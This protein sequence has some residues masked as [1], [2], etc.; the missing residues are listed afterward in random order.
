M[1]AAIAVAGATGQVDQG[2]LVLTAAF[3]IGTAIP[4]LLF[5]YAGQ[6]VGTRAARVRAGSRRF[7]VTGGVV[8]IVLAAAL[9]FNLTGDLPVSS[10][11]AGQL[12]AS[13]GPDRH[14]HLD[15]HQ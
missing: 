1:I 15:Q 6:Q 2:V 11:G 14:R 10:R 9:T 3:S 8:M 12:R 4:L 5:A 13:T 7:R